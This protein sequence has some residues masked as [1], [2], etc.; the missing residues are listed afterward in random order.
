M[1]FFRHLKALT[2]QGDMKAQQDHALFDL[3]TGS[4]ASFTIFQ[5]GGRNT[6]LY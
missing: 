3:Q 5:H 1:S 2:R 6:A 4:S